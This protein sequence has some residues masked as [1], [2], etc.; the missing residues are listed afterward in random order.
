MPFKYGLSA[1]LQVKVEEP[2]NLIP[3]QGALDL[4]HNATEIQVKVEM[5]LENT[6][7]KLTE[8]DLKEANSD[9]IK[10]SFRAMEY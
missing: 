3:S 9:E 8:T 10:K 6:I 4:K 1:S 7:S 2:E 5:N